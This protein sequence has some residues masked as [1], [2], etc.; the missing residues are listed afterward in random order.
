VLFLFRICFVNDSAVMLRGKSMQE[1]KAFKISFRAWKGNR[2]TN[3]YSNT[4]KG[5]TKP[6]RAIK[7]LTIWCNLILPASSICSL[8]FNTSSAQF[9]IDSFLYS[10]ERSQSCSTIQKV[11]D[12]WSSSSLWRAFSRLVANQKQH[13]VALIP[14]EWEHFA[15]R[16]PSQNSIR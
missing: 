14:K 8:L 2:K 6:N 15:D 3:K 11:F 13:N 9:N 16:R 5:Y 10:E 4:P 1:W 12:Y 7:T